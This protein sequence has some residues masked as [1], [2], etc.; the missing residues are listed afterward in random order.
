[1]KKP[2]V[3]KKTIS[4]KITSFAN[5]GSLAW[6]NLLDFVDSHCKSKKK[7]EEYLDE[8]TKVVD[9]YVDFNCSMW[10][11][12]WKNNVGPSDFFCEVMNKSFNKI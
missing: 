8:L 3:T 9:K 10:H 2:K 12:C 5:E 6:K 11:W 7:R 1:M 4:R